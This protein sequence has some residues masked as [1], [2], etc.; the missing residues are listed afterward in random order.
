MPRGDHARR[1]RTYPE[2]WELAQDLTRPAWQRAEARGRAGAS[3]ADEARVRDDEKQLKHLAHL[4]AGRKPADWTWDNF[5]K[6][7]EISG[8]ALRAWEN[9]QRGIDARA[10]LRLL[11]AAKSMGGDAGT[12]VSQ[13][14]SRLALREVPG[15]GR[16]PRMPVHDLEHIR[17]SMAEV[18]SVV[19]RMRKAAIDGMMTEAGILDKIGEGT[20]E[21]VRQ[22]MT[23]M[24]DAFRSVARAIEA[25]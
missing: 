2:L 14:R 21:P 22:L 19:S 5:Q 7:M 16:P 12:W 9:G 6:Q 1:A 15:I 3:D 17:R 24:A 25:G 4:V 23:H 20:D 8:S 18:T 10:A 13:M 11:I